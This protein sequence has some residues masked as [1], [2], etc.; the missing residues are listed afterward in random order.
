MELGLVKNGFSSKS[1][2][3]FPNGA[4]VVV[5][6]GKTGHWPVGVIHCDH[7]GR[8]ATPCEAA[9]RIQTLPAAQK[10]HCISG[11]KFKCLPMT[12]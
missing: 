7:L 8:K 5:R 6:H 2:A 3:V 11:C 1:V 12:S 10:E 9:G 4:H